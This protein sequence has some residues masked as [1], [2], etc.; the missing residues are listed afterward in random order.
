[1]DIYGTTLNC[2]VLKCTKKLINAL[3]IKPQSHKANTFKTGQVQKERDPVMRYS[4]HTL[5]IH[6]TCMTELH[7]LYTVVS[8]VH[9]ALAMTTLIILL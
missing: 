5:G 6:C 7:D 2:S 1:M 4:V 8:Q 3:I 9:I